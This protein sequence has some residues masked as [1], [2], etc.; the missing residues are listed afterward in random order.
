[1]AKRKKNPVANKTAA[2]SVK[3]IASQSNT[4]N[5]TDIPSTPTKASITSTASNV[6]SNTSTSKQ[7]K[8]TSSTK[9]NG[10]GIW[11]TDT[12]V[13]EEKIVTGKDATPVVKEVKAGKIIDQPEK[14]MKHDAKFDNKLIDAA[15][16]THLERRRHL[17]VPIDVQA[18][19][20]P[21]TKPIKIE[22]DKNLNKLFMLY[23]KRAPLKTHFIQREGEEDHG[24]SDWR[25]PDA[26]TYTPNNP[27]TGGLEPGVHLFWKPPRALLEGELL[28]KED[29]MNEFE[30]KETDGNV[31]PEFISTEEKF[32]HPIS[33][34]DAIRNRV[35]FT[36]ETDDVKPLNET[37][38]FPY[39]PDL[40]VII[41]RKK[42]DDITAPGK[43]VNSTK[44]EPLVKAWVVD[45]VTLEVSTLNNFTPTK[46]DPSIPEMTAIGP[47]TGD[48]HWTATYDNSKG[49]FGFHDTLSQDTTAT[50]DYLVCG[51]FTDESSD[52][53]YME[54]H[55]SEEVW[56]SKMR[57]DLRWDVKR[58]DIDDDPTN[59]ETLL[60]HVMNQQKGGA[61]K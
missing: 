14:G 25:L 3:N 6:K 21:Y 58:S 61:E 39:L 5:K 1:M 12:V 52:P 55:E 50:F 18:L 56:F 24:T 20:V 22:Q 8:E 53:A 44:N 28:E 17:L 48:M 34:E 40:W 33:F 19:V 42:V 4:P 27:S 30:Y 11:K 47:E 41:R 38:K 2:D 32:Q 23:D 9:T 29:V 57:D 46:R 45:S 13:S 36:T 59:W 37:L 54:A 35:E 31:P 43:V 10:D 15:F 7:V 26:F 16:Q 51:W 60:T 49:R